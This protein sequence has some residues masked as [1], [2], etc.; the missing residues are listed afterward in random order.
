MPALLLALALFPAAA[1]AEERAP[2]DA[3]PAALAPCDPHNSLSFAGAEPAERPALRTL[4]REPEA[5]Q[6]LGVL[7]SEGGCTRPIKA[8]GVFHG[9]T[10]ASLPAR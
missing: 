5:T 6:Y 8:R 3:A 10:N 1:L 9:R 4:D 7:R 2:V